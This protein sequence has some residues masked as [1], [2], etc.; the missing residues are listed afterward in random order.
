MPPAR[1][2]KRCSCGRPS[3]RRPLLRGVQIPAPA[4]A[5]VG[6]PAV[7]RRA[8]RRCRRSP[9]SS[10][11]SRAQAGDP[12]PTGSG[13]R[14]RGARRMDRSRT[15]PARASA[16]PPIPMTPPSSS[17]SPPPG[18]PECQ[19]ARRAAAAGDPARPQSGRRRLDRRPPRPCHSTRRSRWPRMRSMT[20]QQIPYAGRLPARALFPRLVAPGRA[21]HRLVH[22][23]EEFATANV[24]LSCPWMN[25]QCRLDFIC[26]R[27][28][29]RV[30]ALR[31]RAANAHAA[32]AAEH[33]GRSAP[34][35]RSAGARS[36]LADG[37]AVAAG[38]VRRRGRR[39]AADGPRR[40][41]HGRGRPLGS[42]RR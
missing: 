29:H 13:A 20:L 10:P 28:I 32:R 27:E 30:E 31:C 38:R 35:R 23:R 26:T 34:G 6:W 39:H 5:H 8:S 14:R 3:D 11:K 4:F 40:D 2:V 16:T 22:G 42:R 15:P 41:A 37:P 25:Q 12:D 7:P 17:T 9:V 1:T 24:Q 33:F 18:W 21:G 36:A 19:R